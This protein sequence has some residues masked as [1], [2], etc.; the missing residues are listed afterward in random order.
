MRGK[1]G[2][3]RVTEDDYRRFGFQE[4]DVWCGSF[5]DGYGERDLKECKIC[6]E[7]IYVGDRVRYC[8]NDFQIAGRGLSHSQCVRDA[9]EDAIWDEIDSD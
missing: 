4:D 7:S 5:R 2:R 8:G 3:I 1:N 9:I 6:G